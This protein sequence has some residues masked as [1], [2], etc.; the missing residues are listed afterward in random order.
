MPY[1][2][3]RSSECQILNILV[4]GTVVPTLMHRCLY[5]FIFETPLEW[6]IG[7][8]ICRGVFK[9]YVQSCNAIGCIRWWMWLIASFRNSPNHSYSCIS[10]WWRTSQCVRNLSGRRQ[11]F[12]LL[13][14]S[15]PRIW[16]IHGMEST[17]TVNKDDDDNDDADQLWPNKTKLPR[18]SDKPTGQNKK[19]LRITFTVVRNSNTLCSRISVYPGEGLERTT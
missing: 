19:K 2:F 6:R 13:R 1:N 3:N 15:H 11:N 5:S 9:T 18:K 12:S 8:K 7:A 16:K 17:S 4:L 14:I 10:L